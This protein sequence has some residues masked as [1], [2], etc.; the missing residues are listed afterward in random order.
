M[1]HISLFSKWVK[2]C[3]TTITTTTTTTTTAATTTTTTTTSTTTTTTA[4]DRNIA[5]MIFNII[6][7]ILSDL[8]NIMSI[9]MLYTVIYIDADSIHAKKHRESLRC[10]QAWRAQHPRTDADLDRFCGQGE[11]ISITVEENAINHGG[12]ATGPKMGRKSLVDIKLGGG[13]IREGQTVGYPP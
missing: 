7:L 9:F 8:L 4:T 11:T 13:K 1:R 3:Q 10:L 5:C 12:V 6:T 2:S